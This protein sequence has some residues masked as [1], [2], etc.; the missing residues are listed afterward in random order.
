MS[1]TKLAMLTIE[2]LKP[3][4]VVRRRDGDPSGDRQIVS[5]TPI[6]NGRADVLHLRR[7][8]NGRFSR[9]PVE[10]SIEWFLQPGDSIAPAG[11]LADREETE[12][13]AVYA[14]VM[15]DSHAGGSNE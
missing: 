6:G 3:G 12:A 9:V 2:D 1:K 4:D 5:V 7:T 11:G 14:E 8:K 15:D 10:Q 13:D